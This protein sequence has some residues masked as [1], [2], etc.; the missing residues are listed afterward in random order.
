MTNAGIDFRELYWYH[1]SEP[2][3]LL[4]WMIFYPAQMVPFLPWIVIVILGSI[5]GEELVDSNNQYI[6]G[7][8]EIYGKFYRK[9]LT[10]GIITTI[11]GILIGLN[12]KTEDYGLY[13]LIGVN[14]SPYFEWVGIPEFWVHSSVPSVIYTLGVAM[15][16]LAVA[17]NKC[18]IKKRQGNIVQMYTFFGR[19]SLSLYLFQPLFLIGTAETMIVAPIFLYTGLVIA[20][21]GWILY[22]WNKKF[23][24]VGSP[25]WFVI[26][27]GGLRKSKKKI[28]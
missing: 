13:T 18:E 17:F 20:I 6:Q 27:I 3:A 25:E 7:N 9:L 19:V 22:Y 10:I 11:I 16:M 23:H 1:L 12:L 8:K 14:S 28:H 24:L 4:F 5:I 26:A 2:A 15:I 21:L